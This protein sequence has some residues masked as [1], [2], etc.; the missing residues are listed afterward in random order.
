M[1]KAKKRGENDVDMWNWSVIKFLLIKC[2]L[3]EKSILKVLLLKRTKETIKAI[4]NS[5]W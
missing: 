1:C 4:Q 5:S 2:Y 3:Q